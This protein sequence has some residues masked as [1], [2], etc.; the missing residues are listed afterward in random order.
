MLN[1]T[2]NLPKEMAI[3]EKI[4]L[5]RFYTTQNIFSYPQFQEWF[6]KALKESNNLVLEPFAGSNN[7]IKMLQDKGYEFDFVSYDINPNSSEVK[8]RDTIKDFPHGYKLIITNPPYLAKNS[9]NRKKITG[10]WGKYDDLYKLCLEKMLTHCQYV[11]AIVPASFINSDLFLN[12]LHSYTLLN[13]KMF[14]DTETPACL[15]LFSPHKSDFIYL[16]EKDRYVG[17]LYSLKK[18]LTK[19]LTNSVSKSMEIRFNDKNGNI[20][21]CAIDNTRAPS[22]AFIPSWLVPKKRIKTS[23]RH[24]TRISIKE[25]V[26]LDLL[27]EKL[28]QIREFTCDFLLTPFRGLRKDGKFR[29]RLDF[30]L[31]RKIIESCVIW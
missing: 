27:N 4:R 23:S 26:D 30:Q 28:A 18:K 21:L 1:L 22:I 15:V 14:T 19:I 6:N 31:A 16:Y 7:L 17:E 11:A 2:L 3:F 29:R 24:L 13:S 8:K 20:G 5:G 12:R 10:D 9:A 25:K